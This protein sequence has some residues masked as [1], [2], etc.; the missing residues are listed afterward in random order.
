MQDKIEKKSFISRCVF[1]DVIKS[2]LDIDYW[3]TRVENE[4]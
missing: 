3:M 2:N 1:N 4:Q